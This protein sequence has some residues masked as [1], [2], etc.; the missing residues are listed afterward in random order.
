MLLLP[1]V[2]SADELTLVRQVL[3]LAEFEDGRLTA[4]GLAAAA[5][6]N[7]Q[8]RR[9]GAQEEAALDGAIAA[10]LSRHAL[11][12]AAVL[13]CQFTAPLFVRYEPGMRYGAHVDAALMGPGGNVRTDVSIT[14][15]LNDPSEYEGGELAIELPGGVRQVKLPAGDAVAYPTFAVHQVNPVQSGQ[16]LVAVTWAQS[17]VRDPQMREVLFDLHAAGQALG[18]SRPESLEH[19]LLQKAATNLLRLVAD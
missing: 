11:F 17:R 13:P 8:L 7:R 18:E 5:K 16:R 15:F 2:L 9:T 14:V 19:R 12:C 6:D 4:R 3:E 1:G 10:A